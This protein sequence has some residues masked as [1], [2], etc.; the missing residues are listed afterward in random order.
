VVEFLLFAVM[1]MES[2]LLLCSPTYLPW[3]TQLTATVTQCYI[4]LKV[5]EEAA[6]SVRRQLGLLKDQ[7]QL[8]TLEPIPLDPAVATVYQQTENRLNVLLFRA[9]AE[10]AASEAAVLE[11]LAALE[12]PYDRVRAL[13]EALRDPTRRT[14]R[15]GALPGT[16]HANIMHER[17]SPA[18][19]PTADPAVRSIAVGEL[20]SR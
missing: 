9:T 15:H 14:V 1:A 3:R 12:A 19:R 20:D 10:G 8:E 2:V 18:C 6:K 11:A 4:D 7:R 13:L 17:G 16:P 5:P